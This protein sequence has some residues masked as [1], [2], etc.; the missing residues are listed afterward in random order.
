MAPR[1]ACR[2]SSA[3]P[4]PSLAAPPPRRR[5][6]RPR[7]RPSRRRSACCPTEVTRR[8]SASARSA[9]RSR[10]ASR[11]GMRE[12]DLG[13]RRAGALRGRAR[14]RRRARAQRQEPDA[15]D[16]RRGAAGRARRA[17][18]SP[19]IGGRR[20]PLRDCPA[21]D[22]FAGAGGD[23]PRCSPS[24]GP[25]RA[26][27]PA[28]RRRR[29]LRRRR[30]RDR[31]TAR[32][33]A[34]GPPRRRRRAAPTSCARSTATGPRR[35]AVQVGVLLRP[36]IDYDGD[37]LG[38]TLP[39]ARARVQMTVGPRLPRPTTGRLEI[40]QVALPGIPITR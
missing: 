4:E 8:R 7:S 1:R 6:L 24:C 36:N 22:R 16:D 27:R 21:L 12:S 37:L 33:R 25:S 26:G 39:A 23:A 34:A 2:S 18:T 29:G 17:C 5:P 3:R 20:S 35:S 11:I 40:V 19:A 10:G 28:D 38:A 30:R 32:R 9:P 15:V 31:R 14:D 13:G